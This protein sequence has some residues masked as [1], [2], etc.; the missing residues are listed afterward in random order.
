MK[1]FCY[2]DAPRESLYWDMALLCNRLVI[3]ISQLVT[4]ADCID[5][6]LQATMSGCLKYVQDFNECSWNP[7]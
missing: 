5:R 3:E 7:F 4:R 6:A 1:N 2:S